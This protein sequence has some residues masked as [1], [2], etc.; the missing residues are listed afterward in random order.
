MKVFRKLNEAP[1]VTG[2]IKI[3]SLISAWLNMH[4]I[5]QLPGYFVL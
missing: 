1:L 5:L 3:R 2:K 4:I